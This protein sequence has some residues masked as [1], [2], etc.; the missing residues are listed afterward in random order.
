M[1]RRI[2]AFHVLLIA[3]AAPII[4]AGGAFPVRLLLPEFETNRF[5]G[6]QWGSAQGLGTGEAH[7]AKRLSKARAKAKE[8]LWSL[9][10]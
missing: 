10:R 3:V 6:E 5:S 9:P 1:M 8:R 7:S 4:S 2:F